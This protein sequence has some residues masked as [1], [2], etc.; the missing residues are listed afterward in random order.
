MTDDQPRDLFATALV[1]YDR[2][3]ELG[4]TVE[5]E[6]TYVTKLAEVGRARLRAAVLDRSRGAPPDRAAA[7]ECSAENKIL[8]RICPRSRR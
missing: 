3:A 1:A 2:L 4:E 5:G 6:W 7:I 8:R